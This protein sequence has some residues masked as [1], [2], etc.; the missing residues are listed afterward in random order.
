M[1][2][3]DYIGMSHIC[4]ECDAE[5]DCDACTGRKCKIEQEETK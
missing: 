4:E 5:H 3:I 1:T 2:K